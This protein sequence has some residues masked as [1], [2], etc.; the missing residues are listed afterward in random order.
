M[1]GGTPQRAVLAFDPAGSYSVTYDV[2]GA[3][4]GFAMGLMDKSLID[5]SFFTALADAPSA[6]MDLR[7]EIRSLPDA[8]HPNTVDLDLMSPEGK[9]LHLVARSIQ[10]A[11][12]TW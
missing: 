10:R 2:Q 3:D 1:L 7:Y 4:R 12:E 8:D 6:G 5:E 11:A 9:S